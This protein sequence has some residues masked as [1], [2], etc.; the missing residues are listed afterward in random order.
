MIRK[1]FHNAGQ[2][3]LKAWNRENN[4][5]TFFYHVYDRLHFIMMRTGFMPFAKTITA[6]C[7]ERKS[8]FRQVYFIK[9]KRIIEFLQILFY[10]LRQ[11]PCISF[12]G[13][14]IKDQY[15]H[16]LLPHSITS[17]QISI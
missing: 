6:S 1:I 2:M 10:N 11:P 14:T 9:L 17:L 15:F 5:I 7:A 8:Y 3:P 12:V 4:C 16:T 13:S